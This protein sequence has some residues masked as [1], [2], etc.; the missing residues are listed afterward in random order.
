MTTRAAGRNPRDHDVIT[1][2]EIRNARA[3]FDDDA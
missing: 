2:S 1:F 3:Q